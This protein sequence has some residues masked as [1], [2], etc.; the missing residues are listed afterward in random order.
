MEARANAQVIRANVPL[1]QMFGCAT[2][3]RSMTQGRATYTMQFSHYSQV[4]PQV[5]AGI[6][7][8]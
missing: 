6:V 2:D 8:S 5:A 7:Y 1:G 4:P 3:V